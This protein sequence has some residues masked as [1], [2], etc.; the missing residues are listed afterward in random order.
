MI[1][2]HQGILGDAI[3][4]EGEEVPFTMASNV[5]VD[6]PV[7]DAQ[8]LFGTPGMGLHIIAS[9]HP[10][11]SESPSTGVRKLGMGQHAVNQGVLGRRYSQRMQIGPWVAHWSLG[12]SLVLGWLIDT[13]QLTIKLPENKH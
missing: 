9:F 6:L 4:I 12:G 13:W 7:N 1:S 2:P 8:E 3:E 10:P 5:M 11:S